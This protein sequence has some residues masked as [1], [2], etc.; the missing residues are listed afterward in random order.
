VKA[1]PGPSEILRANRQTAP[2][3]ILQKLERRARL[4][5]KKIVVLQLDYLGSFEFANRC[6][7]SP[8]EYAE[9]EVATMNPGYLITSLSV[10]V[11]AL[12]IAVSMH[13]DRIARRRESADR[14]RKS[15]GAIAAKLERFSQVSL[16][17]FADVQPVLT[18]ADTLVVQSQDLVTTRDTLWQ[19][20]VASRAATLRRILEEEIEVS[21][22]DL[23]GYDPRI[24]DL[25]LAALDRLKQFDESAYL[26]LLRDSQRSVLALQ[27]EDRPYTSAQL[28]NVLRAEAA[29]FRAGCEEQMSETVR[30]FEQEMSKLIAARDAAIVKKKVTIGN[31]SSLF[32][33]MPELIRMIDEPAI[34][35]VRN[36]EEKPSYTRRMIY[37]NKARCQPCQVG[38]HLYRL[39]PREGIRIFPDSKTGLLE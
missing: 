1:L 13:K 38:R 35:V 6:G 17:F 3:A 15:A 7:Q 33:P 23:Y 21:Y 4:R 32:P 20:L 34:L 10:L 26:T 28:G 24:R 31:P 36:L 19:R 30:L 27:D 39:E 25:F 9:T 22:S 8:E 16:S 5:R 12:A 37:V 11:S 14:I 18:E 29:R 2:A